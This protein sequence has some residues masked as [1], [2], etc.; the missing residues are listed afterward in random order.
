MSRRLSLHVIEN[1]PLKVSAEELSLRYDNDTVE[2]AAGDDVYLCRCGQTG[3]APFCDGSHNREGFDGTCAARGE[4]DKAVVVWEGRNIKTFYNPNVCM[5]VLY[6]KPLKTLR[7]AELDGDD[8]AAETIA[9]VVMTCPSG[10]LTYEAKDP[11]KVPAPEVPATCDVDVQRGGEVRI[12]VPFEINA[13]L[14]EG[15]PTDRAT[16]CRCG[17]SANKPWCDG[18]HREREN[19]A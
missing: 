1:G 12:K 15:Q 17:L 10:A 8:G 9:K 5:H 19:W 14:H 16:L 4:G 18:K 6:C 3:N 7:K 2:V 11:E 13:A